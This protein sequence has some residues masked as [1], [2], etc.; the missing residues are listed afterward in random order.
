M[1][2]PGFGGILLVSTAL[3]SSGL[4]TASVPIGWT[5]AGSRPQ[6]YEVGTIAAAATSGKVSAYLK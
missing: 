4:A 3:L 5:L 1:S 2:Y 6:D